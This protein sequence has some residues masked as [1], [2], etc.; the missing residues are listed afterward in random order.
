MGDT[1]IKKQRPRMATTQI[2]ACGFIIMILVG[3]FTSDFADSLSRRKSHKFCGCLIYI[4]NSKLR[5]RSCDGKYVRALEFFRA[6]CDFIFDSIWR[7]RSH[8]LYDYL[9]F[10]AGKKNYFASAYA[11]TGCI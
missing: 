8:H 1:E 3:A 7:T 2:I 4:D 6:C 9:F 10:S 5:D 11:Y